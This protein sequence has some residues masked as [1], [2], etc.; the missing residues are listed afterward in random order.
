MTQKNKDDGKNKQQK[1]KEQEQVSPR[2]MRAE[3]ERVS[4]NESGLCLA[5][6][7]M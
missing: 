6:M 4:E 2:T 3:K 5:E 1:K 7:K